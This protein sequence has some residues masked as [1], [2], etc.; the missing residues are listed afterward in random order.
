VLDQLLAKEAQAPWTLGASPLE[1]SRVLAIPELALQ[2]VLTLLAEEGRLAHRAGHYST[3][4]FVPRVSA[5]QRAFFET[6]FPLDTERR[7]IPVAFSELN[8]K[9]KSAKIAGLAQ[10]LDTLLASGVL[11]NVGTDV[12]R[13]EQVEAVR[14][15][16]EERLRREGRITA[17][18]FRTLL[19]TSRKYAVALLEWF[20]SAG[21]TRRDGDAHVLRKAPL[22]E[23]ASDR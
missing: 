11:V 16:L 8:E 20:D 12:Y 7:F 23:R 19:G 2:R 1:L 6:A 9:M 17:A 21:V 18:D 22:R 5:E 4:E 10:S 15:S 13:D 14:A 3:P